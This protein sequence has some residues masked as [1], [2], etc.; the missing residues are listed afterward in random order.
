MRSGELDYNRKG[1]GA[2]TVTCTN[3][4]PV[5][6]ESMFTSCHWVELNIVS[7]MV[8]SCSPIQ[9]LLHMPRFQCFPYRKISLVKYL[10]LL[11]SI[12][13]LFNHA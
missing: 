7:A 11:K 5:N 1:S 8:L 4:N 2:L 13:W 3:R 6:S 9:L 10:A 12:E